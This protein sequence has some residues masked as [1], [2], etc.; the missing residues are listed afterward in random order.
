MFR[1]I[2]VDRALS[3]QARHAER[4]PQCDLDPGHVERQSMKIEKPLADKIAN[5]LQSQDFLVQNGNPLG[6]AAAYQFFDGFRPLEV[7]GLQAQQ[8]YITGSVRG[9]FQRTAV[10]IPPHRAQPRQ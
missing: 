3:A 2:D 4:P 1:L 7:K 6:T 10:N 9:V 5:V 8:S